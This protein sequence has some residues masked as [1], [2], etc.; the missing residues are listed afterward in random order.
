MTQRDS[1]PSTH[2][3]GDE[4]FMSVA[5]LKAYVAEVESAK[6]SQS[7]GSVERAEKAKKDMI[8]KLMARIELTPE[9]IQSFLSRVK[10]A[11][12]RGE[13][14]MMVIRFP[15]ELWHRSWPRHQQRRSRVAG[16]AGRP[17]APILRNLE[18]KT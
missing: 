6:A 11:A 16:N 18:R 7:Y 9:R 3:L 13:S 8:D 17:A 15:S 12:A 5:D 4:A 1:S 10:A 14:E 2:E